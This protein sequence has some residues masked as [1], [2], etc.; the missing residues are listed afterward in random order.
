[1]TPEELAEQV[2]SLEE[3]L[4]ANT[5]CCWTNSS[6]TPIRDITGAVWMTLMFAPIPVRILSV[7]LSWEYWNLAASDTAYW[8]ADL[9]VRGPSTSGD[10]DV[11]ATKTTQLT[12]ATANGPVVARQA[13]SFDSANWTTADLQAGDALMLKPAPVGSPASNWRLPMTATVRYRPL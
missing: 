11:F 9:A 2:P 6:Q 3:L 10:Y 7:T 12:G 4:F 5:V 8:S 1:M 13:W